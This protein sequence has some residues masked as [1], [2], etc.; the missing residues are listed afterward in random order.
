MNDFLEGN[1][2]ENEKETFVNNHIVLIIDDSKFIA[3]TY[4]QILQGLGY[5]VLIACDGKTGFSPPRI[6]VRA[7]SFST[8]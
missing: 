5:R 4:S 7:S 8:C 3:R 1:E 2:K 6:A